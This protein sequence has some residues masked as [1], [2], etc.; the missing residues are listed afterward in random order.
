[1]E[2]LSEQEIER[3]FNLCRLAYSP[4]EKQA[5]LEGIAKIVRYIDQLA[6]VPTDEVAPCVFAVLLENLGR[7]DQLNDPDFPPLSR[8]EFLK[9]APAH[10]AGMV[11]VPPIMNP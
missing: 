3:L 9:A 2:E 1:M 11:R 8:D 7:E 6:A 10:T 4:E 5:A